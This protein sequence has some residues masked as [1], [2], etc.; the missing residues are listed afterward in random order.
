LRTC[1]A[2][3]VVALRDFVTGTF[4]PLDVDEVHRDVVHVGSEVDEV[5]R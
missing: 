2:A 3:D 5:R 1:E 4:E